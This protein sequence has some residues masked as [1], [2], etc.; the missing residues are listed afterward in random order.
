MKTEQLS[1]QIED[2]TASIANSIK[3]TEKLKSKLQIMNQLKEELA[4]LNL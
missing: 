3:Y 2:T 1:Q 4:I